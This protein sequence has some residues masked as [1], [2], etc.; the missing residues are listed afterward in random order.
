[1]KTEADV[2]RQGSLMFTGLMFNVQR[3]H[4]VFL[5][6]LIFVPLKTRDQADKLMASLF[7]R[8]RKGA[9]ALHRHKGLKHDVFRMSSCFLVLHQKHLFG[10]MSSSQIIVFYPQEANIHADD[11]ALVW[12]ALKICGGRRN[13]GIF[14]AHRLLD[15]K[16]R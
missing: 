15:S 16:D 6:I 3:L 10:L 14:V 2:S 4:G 1:M 11:V 13:H 5:F 7:L 12:V 8:R 9:R